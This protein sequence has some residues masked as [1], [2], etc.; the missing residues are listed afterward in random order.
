MCKFNWNVEEMKLMNMQVVDGVFDCE[1]KVSC[2]EKIAFIDSMQDGLMSYIVSVGEKFLAEKDTLKTDECGNIKTVSLKA[3]MNRNDKKDKFE[4]QGMYEVLR[5]RANIKNYPNVHPIWS[6]DN[7]DIVDAVFNAQL[8]K[9]LEKEKY[10]FYENDA[11]N[12]LAKM[13]C[14]KMAKYGYDFGYSLTIDG[15][16]LTPRDYRYGI[17]AVEFTDWDDDSRFLT[18]DE[19]IRVSELLDTLEDSYIKAQKAQEEFEEATSKFETKLSA[20]IE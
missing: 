3:W 17:Y 11:D 1:D 9:C 7:K 2:E 12:Q 6:R 14:Q 8:Q 19:L 4:E 16:Y 20:V 10:Y 5:L 15:G 13:V 18:P